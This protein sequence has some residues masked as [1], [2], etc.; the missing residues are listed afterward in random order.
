M[1]ADVQKAGMWKRVGAWFLDL[2]LLCMLAVGVGALLSVAFGYETYDQTLQN[3]YDTYEE[4]FGVT[5]NIT[6]DAYLDMTEQERMNYDAAYEQL[7]ADEEVLFAYN[8]VVN[9]SVLT[10]TLSLLASAM[11]LEFGVPMLLKNGQTVGKKAFGIG[12]MRNDCVKV[13]T[14][15]MFV[16]AL[17]GKY[18]VD[19]MIPVYIVLMVFWGVMDI[20]GTVF[21]IALLA[22]QLVCLAVTRNNS[23]IH[24]LL[25]GTVTVELA[26]QQVFDSTEALV[27][28]TKR[29]HADRAKRD[30]Y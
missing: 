21:L 18:T 23:A 7:L 26:S 17:F 22:G 29:I 9:L 30:N 24:D 8:M 3:G 4:Q 1:G 11:I 14:L 28:Y 19:T 6:Q 13:N 12:V 20:S 10:V 16:R 2:I 27:E 25:A 15:Q 5:F